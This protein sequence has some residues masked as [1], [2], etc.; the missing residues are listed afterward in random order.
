[1]EKVP[2]KRESGYSLVELL[3]ALSLIGLILAL[4]Y[5]IYTFGVTVYERGESQSTLQREERLLFEFLS[6]ELMYAFEVE[7]LDSMDGVAELDSGQAILYSNEQGIWKK[8]HGQTQAALIFPAERVSYELS[9]SRD[10]LSDSLLLF[11]YTVSLVKKPEVAHDIVKSL[12]LFNST[13]ENSDGGVLL[14][15]RPS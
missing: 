1:M 12:F 8:Q 2:H 9:F 3:I 6:R 4:A 15:T 14:Y 5:G 11:D 13:L 7:I 10:E